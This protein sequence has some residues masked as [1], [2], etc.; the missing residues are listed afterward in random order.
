MPENERAYGFTYSKENA[1]KAVSES[2]NSLMEKPMSG[3]SDVRDK[4]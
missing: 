4:K 1:E 3:L 2:D